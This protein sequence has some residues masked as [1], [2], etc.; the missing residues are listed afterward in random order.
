MKMIIIPYSFCVDFVKV[1]SIHY[2]MSVLCAH[3]E[4]L[5]RVARG[6]WTTC[7]LSFLLRF[8]FAVFFLVTWSWWTKDPVLQ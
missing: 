1:P 7:M 2:T 6:S 8:L 3:S 5:T 4:Q